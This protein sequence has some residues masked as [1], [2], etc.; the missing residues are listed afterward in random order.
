MTTDSAIFLLY[1]RVRAQRRE[2]GH[3][4][5]DINHSRTDIVVEH[6]RRRGALRRK[7][8]HARPPG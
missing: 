8:V 1:G 3:A 2:G 6:R 7:A 4:F 5:L